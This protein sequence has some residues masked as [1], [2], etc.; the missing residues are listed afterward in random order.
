MYMGD[1]NTT[2]VDGFLKGPDLFAPTGLCD[3]TYESFA[4]DLT[5]TAWDTA[6]YAI[7]DITVTT[8]SALSYKFI[9]NFGADNGRLRIGWIRVRVK[10]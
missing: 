1:A 3:S 8:G 7:T 2:S 10:R 4:T 6:Q 5:G 9:S